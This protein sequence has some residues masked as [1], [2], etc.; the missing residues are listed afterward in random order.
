MGWIP[1]GEFDIYHALLISA[2]AV[3]TASIASL[4][5]GIIMVIVIIL[6]YKFNINPDNVATPIAA[7][8][9]DLTTLGLL[10][11][12]A[13]FLY[14]AIGSESG[15]WWIS[16]VIIAV[17]LIMLP[18]LIWLSSQNPLTNEVLQTGWVPVLSAM[19]ISSLGGLILDYTVSSYKGIAVFQPVINGVGGNLVA[20]QASRLSTW[21]HQHGRPGCIPERMEDDY[22]ACIN[23][24]AAYCSPGTHSRT[25]R[26]LLMLVIPGHI[27]FTLTINYLKAGHTSLTPVFLVIYFIAAFLQVLLL[28]YIGHV[29]I[30]WMWARSIDPDNSAIPYLTALGDLLGTAFLAIAFHILYLIG[31]R[32]GDVGD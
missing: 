13:T 4:V 27:V 10:S 22:K 24:F 1:D 8:L 19:G 29:M 17:Y 14:K 6:S 26:V 12:I 21:L 18:W 30:F 11:A 2:S 25:A 3:L 9:G 20:V 23:P 16:I 5:L 28:L 7:S 31:D 32:D 15:I